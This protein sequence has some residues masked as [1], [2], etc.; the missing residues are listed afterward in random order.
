MTGRLLDIALDDDRWRLVDGLEQ[1]A[2]SVVDQTCTRLQT[3]RSGQTVVLFSD[4]Q[5]IQDLNDRFRAK[6]QPTNVLS[7]PAPE[8]ADYPGDVILAYET[9]E[10]EAA[11]RGISILNH[12]THLVLHGFL[13]LLGYDHQSN[14]EATLMEGLETEILKE[15]GI[16]DPYAPS[17]KR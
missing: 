14:E 15:L 10:K 8:S 17:D 4:D 11:Q 13:H 12:A 1:K 7:F 3:V 9:C 16:R 2:E 6:N 5:T